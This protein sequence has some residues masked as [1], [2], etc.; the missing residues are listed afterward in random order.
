MGSWEIDIQWLMFFEY[1]NRA[2][3]K[4]MVDHFLFFMLFYFIYYTI[5]VVPIFSPLPPPPS[6]SYSLRQSPGS[7]G[8]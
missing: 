3:T 5:T 1:L 8:P 4:E 6:T 2:V 7:P